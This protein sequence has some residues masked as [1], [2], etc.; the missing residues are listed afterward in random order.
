MDI[1]ERILLVK[2]EVFVFRIPPLGVNKGHKAAEWNLDKPDWTGRL[3]LV[4]IGE[5][6]E[7]R[8]EDKNTGIHHS[9]MFVFLFIKNDLGLLYAKAPIAESNG[10]DFEAVTDSSRYFV[11]RLQNDSG[12]TAF[13]GLGFSD[14]SDSFDLNVSVQD[15][16]KSVK[17]DNEISTNDDSAPKLDLGFKTGETI[18]VNIGVCYLVL[19][20]L[21]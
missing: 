18:T 11:I 17:R 2:H 1:Y 15:H 16:F 20:H 6:L 10:V 14:R 12:Q 13:V 7:L 9:Y 21:C 19:D 5:K 4:S 8:L 3:K